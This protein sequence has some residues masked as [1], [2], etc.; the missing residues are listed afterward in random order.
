MNIAQSLFFS[1]DKE[2][3]NRVKEIQESNKL[4]EEWAKTLNTKFGDKSEDELTPGREARIPPPQREHREGK[5][6]RRGHPGPAEG[7]HGRL[8]Q[9]PGRRGQAPQRQVTLRRTRAPPPILRG[10]PTAARDGVFFWPRN[11]YDLRLSARTGKDAHAAKTP[12]REPAARRSRPAAE[13]RPPREEVLRRQR[14]PD[15]R[16]RVRRPGARSSRS[17]KPA[18]PTWSRPTPPPG[19]SAGSPSTASPPSAT[20]RR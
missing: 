2:W 6:D 1:Q 4:I 5:E 12:T 14:S 18:T 11:R 7:D 20:A 17:S 16:R 3:N 10:P 9:A 13:D 15:L 8:Q 19:G